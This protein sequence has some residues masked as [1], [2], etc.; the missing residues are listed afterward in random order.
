MSSLLKTPVRFTRSFAFR[1]YATRR[2]ERPPSKIKDPLQA[3]N[4]KHYE[5]GPNLTFIHRHPP[6][7][8]TPFSLST[9]PAS[10]LLQ[11]LKPSIPLELGEA[12]KPDSLPPLL[13]REPKG[14]QK[15]LDQ[16]QIEKMKQLRAEDPLK[17][18]QHKLAERFGCSAAFVSIVAPLSKLAQREALARRDEKHEEKK[19]SWG[20]RKATIVAIRKKRKS[21]W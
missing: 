5:I 7:A 2:P 4:A 3:P 10:P 6:T 8:P 21:L 18:T 19:R 13:W 11:P 1:T 17:W 15:K 12:P 16:V 9:A 20:E 14:P